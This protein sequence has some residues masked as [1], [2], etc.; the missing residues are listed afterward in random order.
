MSGLEQPAALEPL[1]K[2]PLMGI[3]GTGSMGVV[4][5]SVDPCT[6]RP[7]AL[8]TLRPELLEEPVAKEYAAR[9]RNE[10]QAAQRLQHPGIVAVHEH[11]DTG[12]FTYISMEYVDAPSLKA[13]LDKGEVFDLSRTVG[14]LAQLLEALQYAHERRVWHRDVKPSNLLLT[15]ADQLKLTDFGIAQIGAPPPKPYELIMGTPGFI[16]P[17]T[18]LSE[19][20]DQ[21]VDLFAA[22]VVL[23][24]LL[25]GVPPY[26]GT[27]DEIMRQ[28][29]C[30]TPRPPS[31][32]GSSP[33][34]QPLDTVVMR[35]L[36]MNPEDRFASAAQF[37]A[38]L[39]GAHPPR[40]GHTQRCC[41]SLN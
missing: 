20:F 21:R 13:C 3:V 35:A 31:V 6:R 14:M 15:R 22:G 8:K 32:V 24:L 40:T 37:R 4:Y 5:R 38:A 30:A 9:L 25:A 16:A 17:E 7:I 12:R 33:V 10:A 19:T 1:G 26:V 39:L 34:V 28:V 23:Y 2:Y 11:G 36:A 27:P 18:Y 41:A 29:C